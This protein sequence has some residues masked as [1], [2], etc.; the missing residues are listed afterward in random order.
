MPRNSSY[1]EKL[2]PEQREAVE[3]TDGPVLIIAGA[4][5]G[6]TRVLTCRT[7]YLL[8]LNIPPSEILAL[9]FTNKAAEEMKERI[10]RE[11]TDEIARYL[12]MGTFHSVFSRILR[13]EGECLGYN[14][15]FS[16]HDNSSSHTLLRRVLKG[17]GLDTNVYIPKDIYAVISRA[18]N[19]LVSADAFLDSERVDEY[20]LRE[21]REVIAE[22]YQKYEA[23]LK[24]NN[25]MD[26]DDLLVNTYRLLRDYDEVRYRYQEQ[27]RYIMVDEFQDTNDVQNKILNLLAESHH[28]L[29]V[30]GDDAQSIYAFRG[31]QIQNILDFTTHYPETK[32][33]KLVTNYRSS[34]EIV[35]M[36]NRLIKKNTGQIPK[37][38]RTA[39]GK[40]TPPTWRL[41]YSDSEEALL[42]AKEIRERHLADGAPY[43]SFA[44]LYR[45]SSQSRVI[46]DNF[47]LEGVPYRIYGGAS[48]YDH[49]EVLDLMAYFRF[50]G[51]PADTE[52]LLRIINLPTRG[53]GER[54]QLHL[55]EE[56]QA[57][58]QTLWEYILSLPNES[59]RLT[60]NALKSV[61]TFRETMKPFIESVHTAPAEM[62]A[63]DIYLRS[64][65][66]NLYE[67]D[68]SVDGETRV[69][70]LHELFSALKD[71]VE[72]KQLETP[73]IPVTLVQYMEEAPFA[74]DLAARDT[75]RLHAVT[76]TTIHSAK[77]LEFNHVYIVGLEEDL[78]PSKR[79]IEDPKGKGLE[80]ERRLCYVAVTRAAHTLS[81]SACQNRRLYGKG[82]IP[83]RPSRFFQELLDEDEYEQ[84][85]S[86]SKPT[87]VDKDSEE[88]FAERPLVVFPKS[89]KTTT[90]AG[91]GGARR[92]E[93]QTQA[94]PP[95]PRGSFGAQP[96]QSSQSLPTIA[97]TDT[98]TGRFR[99]SAQ[100]DL[101][102]GDRVL[103]A[104]FGAGCVLTISGM[105]MEQKVKVVF[106]SGKE[107]NLSVRLAKMK[108]I[109]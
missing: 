25:A 62:M 102:P 63:T 69:S 40:G 79:S 14:S 43:E 51:N 11:V 26:F 16:I 46:E 37:E 77:G 100:G 80:E 84:F 9:T 74:A 7:A 30:V 83:M 17:M 24:E 61:L 94:L 20:H 76:L 101:Q 33:V 82:L 70:H 108:K 19:D 96:T 49:K 60:K 5:S 109:G 66:K 58:G 41:P 97:Q 47:L 42:I 38:C 91:W 78:F 89:G 48:F 95:V 32:L 64:G 1:L 85:K 54:A 59:T 86:K 44:I 87:F 81:L 90:T 75:K 27:F 99:E 104:I 15:N 2:N 6:K 21:N 55:Q 36:A 98:E 53:I 56:A 71:F 8:Q 13:Q 10:A 35:E 107:C 31:A 52:S 73:D 93:R 3:T 106:D 12:V 65:L 28:N 23:A 50:V 105:G 68:T 18:K 67:N 92:G 29:C 88:S 45:N 34:G 57:L 39:R 72:K 22:A 103:H 4:G